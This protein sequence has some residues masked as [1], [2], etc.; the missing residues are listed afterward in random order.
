[1]DAQIKKSSL[2]YGDLPKIEDIWITFANGHGTKFF[3][4]MQSIAKL[5]SCDIISLREG[6]MGDLVTNP[7]N[8]NK[9][10]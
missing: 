3:L 2:S 7:A 6:K 10:R 1:M 5:L 9:C 8:H 4:F